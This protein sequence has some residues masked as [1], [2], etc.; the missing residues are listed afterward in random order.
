MEQIFNLFTIA[1]A[2]VLEGIWLSKQRMENSLEHIVAHYG[3]STVII[4]DHAKRSYG[5]SKNLGF[6]KQSL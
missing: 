3:E 6:P 5:D 1:F 2:N 4:T